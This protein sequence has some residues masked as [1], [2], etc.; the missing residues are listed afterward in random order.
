MLL[1]VDNWS[2]KGFILVN[3]VCNQFELAKFANYIIF[4]NFVNAVCNHY[5][6]FDKEYH[7]IHLTTIFCYFLK[8]FFVPYILK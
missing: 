3:A 8:D 1:Y 2:L 5:E 6:L 4:L 7:L